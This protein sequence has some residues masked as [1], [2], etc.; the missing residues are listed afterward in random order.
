MRRRPLAG[1]PGVRLGPA[2]LRR[3]LLGDALGA[4]LLLSGLL[5]LRGSLG[6]RLLGGTASRGGRLRGARLLLGARRGL[7]LRHLVR[8]ALLRGGSRGL[9]A[10][11]CL[12][13]GDGF[14]PGGSGFL[15]GRS[16]RSGGRVRNDAPL[17]VLPLVCVH[18]V[19]PLIH[20]PCLRHCSNRYR[21]IRTPPAG[22]GGM[23][24]TNTND[25]RGGGVCPYEK[26]THAK[27]ACAL[28]RLRR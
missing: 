20:E 10:G 12:T 17:L 26:K 11:V 22:G 16:R 4:G 5:A 6:A 9:L 21:S 27:S 1:L 28:L 13:V 3:H 24:G 25:G 19:H 14:V 7:A 8:R 18:A 15:R 2:G 23:H